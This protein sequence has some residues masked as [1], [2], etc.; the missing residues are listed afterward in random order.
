[1][2]I[3]ALVL[4]IV[5]SFFGLHA[6]AGAQSLAALSGSD[7]ASIESAC[8]YPKVMEGAAAYHAC[9]NKQLRELGQV[10]SSVVAQRSGSTTPACVGLGCTPTTAFAQQPSVTPVPI[11]GGLGCTPAATVAQRN[12][13]TAPGRNNGAMC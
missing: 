5:A 13:S 9:L 11:C 1:V 6:S 10:G 3:K 2:K 7:R 12:G 4:L 8:N